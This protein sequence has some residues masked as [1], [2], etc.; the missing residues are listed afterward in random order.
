MPLARL[1]WT[2]YEPIHAISYYHPR[3]RAALEAVGLRGAYRSY[4]ASRSAPLGT[5]AAGPVIAAFLTFAPPVVNRALPAVWQLA[6][7]EQALQARLTGAVDALAEL[8]HQQPPA[9]IAEAADRLQEVAGRLEHSGRVLG[10]SNAALPV[11]DQPLARLWQAATTLREHR[12]DGHVA[13]VVAAGLDGCETLVWRSSNDLSRETLQPFRGWTDEQWQAATERLTDR[14]WLDSSGRPTEHGLT[15]FAGIERTTD[16]LAARVWQ[17]MDDD[18]VQRLRE[19]LTPIARAC[20]A[21]LPV[22]N[23]IGL[24]APA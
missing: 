16:E 3:S 6:T 4:F 24:P 12:G 23:M 21:Y 10:A 14:G 2:L 11:P 9:L 5:V 17:S 7:P 18:A 8:T 1:M 22:P 13:A 15:T 19:L 20:F